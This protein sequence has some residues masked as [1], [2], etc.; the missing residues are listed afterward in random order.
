M[1]VS[2][3][4][5][6]VLKKI[7]RDNVNIALQVTSYLPLESEEASSANHVIR[8]EF[9]KLEHIVYCDLLRESIHSLTLELES[10]TMPKC[11]GVNLKKMRK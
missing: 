7:A 1:K 2:K 5:K 8:H 3:K 6:K 9:H 11:D 10:Q 4:V